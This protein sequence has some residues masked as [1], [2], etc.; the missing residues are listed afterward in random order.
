MRLHSSCGFLLFLITSTAPAQIEPQ[1]GGWK[2]WVLS[3]GSQMRLPAP[4]DSSTTPQELPAVRAAVAAADATALA[5]VAYWDSGSPAYQWINAA[6]NQL[7]TRNIGG[8]A[9]TRALALVSVAL[10]DSMVAAWDSKYAFNRPRPSTADPTIQPLVSTLNSPSYP[11]EHA[12]AAGAAA[13]V[14]SYLYPDSAAMF[15][16]MAQEAA[17]S[18]VTAGASFP[19]DVQAGLQLGA[20][21]GAAVVQW[22]QADGSDAPANGTFPPTPGKWTGTNA[23]AP[24]AGLWVPW[25]LNSASDLRPGPP[26]A[27]DSTDGIAQFAAVKNLMRT[28]DMNHTVWFWQ[29][30]FTT[31]WLDVISRKIFEYRLDTDAPRAARIYAIAMVAQHD[32]TLACW[33]AKYV[34]LEPRPIQA[35]PTIVTVYATPNHPGY[36]SGHA[37]VGGSLGTAV[38]YLFPSDPQDF[39]AMGTQAGMSTF[40]AEIHTQLDVNTGLN[41]GSAVGQQVVAH[42]KQD[43]ADME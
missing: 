24:G 29:P 38:S 18:R 23:V 40:F 30:S 12:V 11:S 5:K 41:L 25:V 4:S 21:V 17:Q 14:L 2:T 15:Q 13:A 36:P 16:S 27:V 6:S 43:G 28:T 37:C 34:Y 31:P 22:G 9:S 32:A 8:P 33:D 39:A 20:A 10:Y 1:A 19:S 7:L 3:S 35:D 26:P 42:A